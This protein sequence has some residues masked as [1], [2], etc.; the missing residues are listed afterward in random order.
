MRTKKDKTFYISRAKRDM[1][2]L[3]IYFNITRPQHERAY[4]K[5]GAFSL[6]ELLRQME[7]LSD[8]RKRS[9]CERK[10]LAKFYSAYS[11]TFNYVFGIPKD[12]IVKIAGVYYDEDGKQ[13]RINY[14][15]IIEDLVK[16]G[17]I[18]VVNAGR[19][20]DRTE[21]GQYKVK[22]WWCKKYIMANR[23]HWFKLMTEEKYRD[24]NNYGSDRLRKIVFK[25]I[26]SFKEKR[27]E[28]KHEKQVEV[29]NQNQISNTEANE[30]K[31]VM[32]DSRKK[33]INK[34]IITTCVEA[35]IINPE[36]AVDWMGDLVYFRRQN[37]FTIDEAKMLYNTKSVQN[38]NEFIDKVLGCLIALGI[39]DSEAIYVLIDNIKN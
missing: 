18:K 19:K 26:E 25:W 12:L 3:F 14:E 7:F 8:W 11:K 33:E 13:H 20:F 31:E 30:V 39:K 35:G 2:D 32:N 37:P 5:D 27:I 10:S 21:D 36:T 22:C 38:K 34:K 17:F 1:R 9:K 24:I 23:K 28:E 6:K 4:F 16:E 29:V 15:Q